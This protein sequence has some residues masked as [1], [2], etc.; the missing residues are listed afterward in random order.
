M[1]KCFKCGEEKDLAAF[2]K[3]KQMKDGHVNKC[4]ECTKADVR[5]NRSN[6]L[7]YYREYDRKRGSRL[8][9][10]ATRSYRERNP[11]KWAAH[12][13]INNRV[14]NGTI[15]KPDNCAECGSNEFRL[16]GHHDDYG[17]PLEVRWLCPSCHHQ[18][19]KENGEGKNA[20]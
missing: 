12:M 18:W 2:Y 16:H 15:V 14:K 7:D 19:H 4:K 11:V 17:K 5:T 3:H 1:K 20:S 9:K 6:N 13:M 8:T 10:E